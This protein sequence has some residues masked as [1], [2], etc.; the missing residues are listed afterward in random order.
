MISNQKL[1]LIRLAR[2][3]KLGQTNFFRLMSMHNND[4]ELALDS[5]KDDKRFLLPKKSEILKEISQL[6]KI[7]GQVLTYQDPDYPWLLKLINDFPPVISV[8]G[9]L[10]QTKYKKN[11]SVSIVGSRNCSILG[12]KFTQYITEELVKRNFTI[13]SGLANGI[14]EAAH[15][16]ALENQ[17]NTIAVIGSGLSNFY[18]NT[19]LA[20]EIIQK[21][22]VIISELPFD[23]K[24]KPSFFPR[25]NRIIAGLSLGTLIV[26]A[27]IKSGSMI[28]A[29]QAAKYNRIVFAV[30]G[31]PVDNRSSGTNQLIKDGATMVRDIN[32][33]MDELQTSNHIDYNSIF[34]TTIEDKKE[35]LKQNSLFNNI[36][37]STLNDLETRIIS[38]INGKTNIDLSDLSSILP[39]VYFNSILIAISELEAKNII[40]KDALGQISLI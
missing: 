17:G 12:K 4:A 11:R 10:S 33:I 26:E 5:I 29:N 20:Y 28:T 8:I 19:Q 7:N 31:F 9:D 36:D 25:R 18:P 23:Q 15:E 21:D 27:D 38:A 40:T 13:I 34:S 3:E 1:S 37:F 2:T 16:E 39:D 24:P 32:D 35:F 30:P 6:E 22:G 14:D